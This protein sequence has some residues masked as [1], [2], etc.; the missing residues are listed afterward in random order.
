MQSKKSKKNV[1]QCN[2][3]ERKRRFMHNLRLERETLTRWKPGSMLPEI[4]TT[5]GDSLPVTQLNPFHVTSADDTT[6]P[7]IDCKSNRN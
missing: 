6:K 5:T 3:L 1:C 2:V 7:E 4:T